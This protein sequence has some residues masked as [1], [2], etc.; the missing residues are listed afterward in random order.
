M[1]IYNIKCERWKQTKTA[2]GSKR[3]S[4]PIHPKVIVFLVFVGCCRRRRAGLHLVQLIS[5]FN[6]DGLD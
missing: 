6:D 5:G 3:L 1:I 4:S 2:G